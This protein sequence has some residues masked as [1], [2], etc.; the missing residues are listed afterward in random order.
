MFVHVWKTG[1][2][3]LREVFNEAF[4]PQCVLEDTE[5]LL[6]PLS[7]LNINPARYLRSVR[8]RGYDH[9]GGKL[10]VTGHFWIRKYDPIQAEV[11]ATILREPIERA[12][13]HYYY[14]LAFPKGNNPILRYV[15]DNKLSFEEFARMPAA[16]RAY[17]GYFFRDV[18]MSQ[19]DY[20]GIYDDLRNNFPEVIKRLGISRD[21]TSKIVNDTASLRHDYAERVGNLL[22]D[23]ALMRRL[24]DVFAIDLDFY[25]RYAVGVGLEPL[26]KTFVHDSAALNARDPYSFLSESDDANIDEPC[27]AAAELC[28]AVHAPT[29]TQYDLAAERAHIGELNADREAR[30]RVI[31]DQQEQLRRCGLQIREFEERFERQERDF[32]KAL[33]EVNDDRDARL[34]ALTRQ[35]EVIGRLE[36]LLREYQAQLETANAD[37]EARLQ[38][39]SDQQEQLRRCDLQI[40]RFEQRLERQETDYQRALKEANDDRD[41]RLEALTRQAEV[42]GKLEG[43]LREYQAQLETANADREERLKAI[44]ALQDTMV[45]FQQLLDRCNADREARLE[46]IIRQQETIASLQQELAKRSS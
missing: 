6:N 14:W 31:S 5:D 28:L 10:V 3:F 7:Q 32:R 16:C 29:T 27:G 26:P 37:R 18:D 1:G 30:L 22:S 44:V 42:I 39:I 2:M 9:L 12:I 19:F 20:V 36:A 8:A 33:Q 34:E 45:E 46:T 13:S 15:V 38:A 41:A 40:R 43:L 35:A 17:T 23:A 24:R 21:F 11:R 25:E 4:S